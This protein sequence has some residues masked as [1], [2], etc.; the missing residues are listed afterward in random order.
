MTVGFTHQAVMIETG[1]YG[2]GRGHAAPEQKAIPGT[3]RRGAIASELTHVTIGKGKR[4]CD[5]CND[6]GLLWVQNELLRPASTTHSSPFNQLHQR[7][8]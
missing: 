5:G 4:W 8:E 3:A 7:L 1:Q 2:L 6:L